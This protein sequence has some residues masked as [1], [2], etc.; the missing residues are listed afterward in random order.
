MT[1]QRKMLVAGIVFFFMI[2]GWYYKS[3]PGIEEC[4]FMRIVYPPEKVILTFVGRDDTEADWKPIIEKFIKYKL[5]GKKGIALTMK[6]ERI[7]S[8]SLEHY[9]TL[10]RDRKAEEKGPRIFMM[11]H[12]WLPKYKEKI[13]PLPKGIIKIS[14][15]IDTYAP[16]AVEDLTDPDGTIYSIPLYMDTLALYYNND[17][18]LQEN[19]IDNPRDWKEFENDVAKLAKYEKNDKGEFLLDKNGNRIIKIMGAAIGGGEIGDTPEALKI[20]KSG[21]IVMLLIMQNNYNNKNLVSFGTEGAFNAVKY[22][23]NFADPK[24]NVYTWNKDQIHSVDAF[25]QKKSAIMIDYLS[26]LE[27]VKNKTNNKLNFKI[28]PIPQVNSDQKINYA[29]YWV[30][31]VSA[32]KLPPCSVQKGS[33]INCQQL[34]WEFIQFAAKEENVKL[35][36]D[37]TNKPAANLQLAKEQS[38]E[39]TFRSIFADQALTA[40]S[41]SNIDDRKTDDTLLKMINYINTPDYD[42]K[43]IKEDREQAIKS[44]INEAK[45]YKPLN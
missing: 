23:T 40:R 1:P 4:P 38:R 39:G 25:T 15:Y 9:E 16:A 37:A 31:V 45:R 2:I 24:S 18:F 17:M 12:S 32:S 10:L 21:D 43:R 28:K 34:A 3:C 19:I 30:P 26:Q 5:E 35:Y 22:Y 20:N 27:N 29:N 8:S 7:N 13:V 36:L 42:D 11:F 44:A 41:W 6:Y 33:K 14:D